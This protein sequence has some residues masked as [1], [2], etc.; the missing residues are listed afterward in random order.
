MAIDDRMLMDLASQLGMK[1]SN[2]DTSELIEEATN[3]Y[4]GKSDDQILKEIMK[5]KSVLKKDRGAFDKQM[6]MIKAM[7]PM[8]TPEQ[9]GK[10]DSLLRMLEE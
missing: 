3:K 1:G 7:R 8:M 10:L 5:L 4:G 2:R 9:K 6:E